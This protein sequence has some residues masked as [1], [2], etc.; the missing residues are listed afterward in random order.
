VIATTIRQALD[1][2]CSEI[3]LGDLTPERDFTVVADTAQAFL[4]AAGPGVEPGTV[5]NCGTGRAVTI[6]R[7]SEEI[8]RAVGHSKPVVSEA[9][10]LRPVNSEVRAL[11]ADYARFSN[12]TGW[13]PSTTLTDGL[14][15]TV[16]WWKSRPLNAARGYR[17]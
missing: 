8:L 13:R 12:A 10:R 9:A 3:R 17:T 11:H 15:A 6:G 2:A 1:P 4:A 7:L 14:A 5:Y 16:A